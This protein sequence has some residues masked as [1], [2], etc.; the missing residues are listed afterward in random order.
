MYCSMGYIPRTFCTF[1][2]T[3]RSGKLSGS[4]LAWQEL[5]CSPPSFQQ[6]QPE[7]KDE[8]LSQKAKNG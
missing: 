3:H 6:C 5:F 8:V 2:A 7:I 4:L 1:S